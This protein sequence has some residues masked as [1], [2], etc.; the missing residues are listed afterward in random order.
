MSSNSFHRIQEMMMLSFG[1]ILVVLE[2]IC[3]CN[4]GRDWRLLSVL[5]K[6]ESRREQTR[7][8]ATSDSMLP[9]KLRKVSVTSYHFGPQRRIQHQGEWDRLGAFNSALVKARLISTNR[10]RGHILLNISYKLQEVTKLGCN[11]LWLPVSFLQCS[12]PF[13]TMKMNVYL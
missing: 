1:S 13:V 2:W 5:V 11:L 12:V 8:G 7:L 6:K 4:P 10:F 3:S 9:H